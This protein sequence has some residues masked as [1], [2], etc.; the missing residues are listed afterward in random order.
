MRVAR[1]GQHLL[2]D[3]ALSSSGPVHAKFPVRP[4]VHKKQRLR[5][6]RANVSVHEHGYRRWS[7]PAQ[8]VDDRIRLRQHEIAI[9]DVRQ[10]HHRIFL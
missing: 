6:S 9:D 2:D 3:G 7:R 1:L 4:R 8:I 5:H 10:I